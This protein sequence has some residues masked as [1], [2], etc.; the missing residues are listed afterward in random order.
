MKTWRKPAINIHDVKMDE[1]IAS[2]GAAED[3]TDWIW[4]IN[5][6]SKPHKG[7]AL[8]SSKVDGIHL[9][10]EDRRKAVRFPMLMASVK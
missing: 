8:H 7:G 6:N 5:G 9:F 2:S 3:V 4:Y 1:N 10:L